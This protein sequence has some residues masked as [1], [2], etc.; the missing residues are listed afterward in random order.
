MNKE[1][2]VDQADEKDL[3]YAFSDEALEAAGGSVSFPAWTNI[4]TGI[5]CPG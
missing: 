4:C 1:A 3:A 5:Q 2:T